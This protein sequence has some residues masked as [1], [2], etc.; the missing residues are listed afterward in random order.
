MRSYLFLLPFLVATS[1]YCNDATDAKAA[2]VNKE[3]EKAF[4]LFQ[5]A[6]NEK[7]PNACY[8][9]GKMHELGRGIAKDD[10][11]AQ[12]LYK[13]ACTQLKDQDACDELEAR[14]DADKVGC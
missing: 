13:K 1:S 8:R 5:K 9:L 7:H 10:E 12:R 4:G 11:K 2:C 14:E 6:C 3:Y